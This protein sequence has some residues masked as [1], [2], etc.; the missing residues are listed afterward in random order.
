MRVSNIE[1]TFLFIYFFTLPSFLIIIFSKL[2]H[3]NWDGGS[4][5][6]VYRCEIKVFKNIGTRSNA[7][8]CRKKKNEAFSERVVDL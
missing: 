1:E 8:L 7:L 3:F 4:T 5:E 2:H 6:Q